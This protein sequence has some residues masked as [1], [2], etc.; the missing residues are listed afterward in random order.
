MNHKTVFDF[1]II[2]V[3]IEIERF[4]VVVVV[5]FRC[6]NTLITFFRVL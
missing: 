2:R 5:M 1:E 4:V 3:E 6:L